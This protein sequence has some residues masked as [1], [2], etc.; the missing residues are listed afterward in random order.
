MIKKY[1]LVFILA[2][3]AFMTMGMQCGKESQTI[4]PI[5]VHQYE[6]KLT[7]T[8]FKKVYA[9]ND[10]I[11]IQFKTA[12]KTLFDKLSGY[13]IS[14]DTTFLK[15]FFTLIKQFPFDRNIDTY[16]SAVVENG[17]DINFVPVIP[18]RNDLTFNTYCNN[19]PYFFKVGIV[20]LKTGV[21]SLQ[22]G[23]QVSSCPDKKT[24]FPSSFSY[25]YDLPDCN[26]DVWKS[27]A[28][29]SANGKDSYI[30]SGI[31]GKQIFAIRVE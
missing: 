15:V 29:Q 22:P 18:T 19:D 10:T 2:G 14:T 23:A 17:L 8:P 13:N 27:I 30:N 5:L 25:T 1:S 20:L 28:A 6:A 21:Y 4:I 11:W 16:A 12:D 26:Y 31:E 7:L 24:N 9:I 3:F